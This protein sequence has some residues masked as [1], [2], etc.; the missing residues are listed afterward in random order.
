M[1]NATSFSGAGKVVLS[2]GSVQELNEQLTAA[3][4]MLEHP[5]QVV[6]EI[7]STIAGKRPTSLPADE[8]LDLK[9]VYV[10]LPIR[11]GKP[12]SLSSEEIRRIL[13]CT[14][15]TLRLHS[16]FRSSSKVLPWFAR[17]CTTTT[18]TT[19]GTAGVKMKKGD[20][21]ETGEE[22]RWET[23]MAAEGRPE[24][25][26]RQFS[27]RGWKPSLDTIKEKKFEK[28]ISHWLFKF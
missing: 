6:V 14:N 26:S 12:A 27:G 25:L 5:R 17:V 19:I 10:M 9:K 15:S 4:L 28:K 3:E 7:C 22:N 21:M 1:G 20:N 23:E 18:A 2:D 24:Y 11:G 8:K 16:L 13:L